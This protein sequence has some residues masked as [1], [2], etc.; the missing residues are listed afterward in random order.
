[1]DGGQWLGPVGDGPGGAHQAFWPRSCQLL[2]QSLQ[3]LVQPWSVCL[4]VGGSEVGAPAGREWLLPG[5][6]TSASSQSRPR[7]R[8]GHS[9]GQGESSC[10]AP[11]GS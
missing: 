5:A 6:P 10:R 7:G 4:W 2:V 3:E 8:L 11:R 9:Q 1:M